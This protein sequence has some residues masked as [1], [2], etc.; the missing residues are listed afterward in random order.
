MP[1]IIEN[2][3]FSII[4]FVYLYS[5]IFALNIYLPIKGYIT[6]EFRKYKLN[7]RIRT[8]RAKCSKII[9]FSKLLA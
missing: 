7:M 9:T 3:S 6:T 2:I 4:K 1:P 8:L 5:Y